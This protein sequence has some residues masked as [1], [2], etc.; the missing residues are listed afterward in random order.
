MSDRSTTGVYLRDQDGVFYHITSEM[1]QSARVPS[2]AQAE[3]EQAAA[4]S[5]TAGFLSL[6]FTKVEFAT[7]AINSP[8]DSANGLPTGR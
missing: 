4:A 1:L 8:R 3:L 5:D 7:V 6:N 2:E